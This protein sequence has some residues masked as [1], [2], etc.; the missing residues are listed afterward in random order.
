MLIVAPRTTMMSVVRLY[1][2]YVVFYAMAGDAS[3]SIGY[4]TSAV[5]TN[6]AIVT[7]CAPA[8]WPLARRWFP[9]LFE[10][11]GIN[12]PYY[13]DIEIGYASHRSNI[14][15]ATRSSRRSRI[16]MAIPSWTHHKPSGGQG[17][18]ATRTIGGTSFAMNSIEDDREGDGLSGLPRRAL[19]DRDPHKERRTHGRPLALSHIRDNSD[20]EILET[21][22]GLVRQTESSVIYDHETE[23]TLSMYKST[24]RAT[25]RSDAT[26]HALL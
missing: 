23:T 20:E 24:S 25:D 2:V 4:V 21:Y 6:L 9:G 5:E 17:V 1:Y 7:A 11:L 3:Y 18:L 16:L 10:Q 12:R 26:T 8:L 13:P 15:R 22:H 14:S 19:L